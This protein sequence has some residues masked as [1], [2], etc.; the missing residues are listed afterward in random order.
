MS[1]R[2]LISGLGGFIGS[3]CVSHILVN[4]DWDIVGIDS[5]RHKGISERI[6]ESVHYQRNKHR[7]TVF[8][9]DLNAPVSSIMVQKL[10]K[11]DYV[12]NFAS[13]SHVDRSITDPVPFV[14]N[15][16][17]VI[18]N[19]ME[20]ARELKPEKF[21][22]IGTDE[23]YGPTDGI[24]AHK[25]WDIIRPSNPYSASKACQEAIAIAYWRTY[26]VPVFLTNIMNNFG[27]TQDTEKFVPLIMKKVL[28]G[29]KLFI[30]S[31]KDCK[32]SGS[33]FWLHPRNL[34]DALLFLLREV[35]PKMYPDG[36][37]LPERFNL[38]G[39]EQVSNEKMALMVAQIM[40]KPIHYELQDAHSSR[41][42]HDLHYGLDGTKLKEYG[43]TFPKHFRES[44]E[45]TIK[46]TMENER[47][48][49]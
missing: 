18:L 21:I 10:G 35:K 45:K 15:N 13:A 46:W 40:G 31:D 39:D 27:E 12:I 43:Y 16:V 7:V 38:V 5:W 4:T 29:E 20:L 32:T 34:S 2:I 19:M 41:P 44:L 3:H 48:A 14:Q 37:N 49:K 1:K 28:S 36:H 6:T 24:H 11:I 33:R 22:Q 42:G 25:E 26:N 17:N 47:W 9:H 8:T 23:T 30:H